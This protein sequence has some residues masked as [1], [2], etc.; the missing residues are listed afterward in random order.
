MKQPNNYGLEFSKVYDKLMTSSKYEKWNDLIKEQINKY[1]IKGNAIDLACGTGAIS[2]MLLDLGFNVVGVD[3]SKYMI[4]IAKE[5]LKKYN[6]KISFIIDDLRT[7]NTSKKF[8]FGV[9]FYDSLNYLLSIDDLT[10]VFENIYNHLYPGAY[11][12]FDMNTK[13]HVSVVSRTPERSFEDEGKNITLNFSGQ[14][15]IWGLDILIKNGNNVELK[16]KHLE[17]GYSS[18]EIKQ[19]AKLTGFECVDIIN[20]NKIYWDK[21]E[22]LSRQ[23][24]VLRKKN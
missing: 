7:F 13:E 11:F 15:N 18:E 9:S 20:E 24:Y 5:K 17:R 6:D 10:K 3:K 16:E 14:D 4:N 22:Y 1:N 2:K 21:K 12:L 19:I 23:Y 8:N